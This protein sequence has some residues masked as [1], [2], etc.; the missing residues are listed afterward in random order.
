MSN[1][2]LTI[3]MITKEALRV[4]H[5]EATVLKKVRRDYDD[6]FGRSGAKIGDTL[7]IRRPARYTVTNG[8][9]LQVQDSVETF[10]S[11]P[12]TSQKGVHIAFS[13][14]EMALDIDDYSARY[15]RPA[16]SQLAAQ[17]ESDFIQFAKNQTF[18]TVGAHNANLSTLTTVLNARQRLNQQL[19]PQTP[20]SLV[21][22]PQAEATLVGG[23]SNLFNSQTQV[24]KQYESGS[25]GKAAGFDFYASA[26]MPVHTNGTAVVTG[27]TVN[28]ANQV[29]A[30]IS[31]SSMGANATIPAGTVLT[32]AGC[33]AVNPETKQNLGYLQ[34]FVVTA[35]TTATGAGAVAALPISPAIVTSGPFQNVSASPTASG[36][37]V[38]FGA[39]SGAYDVSLAMHED[40]F[41]FA[42]ADL[43]LPPNVEASRQEMGGLSLRALKVYDQIND[44]SVIRI[45]SLYGFCAL[46]PQLAVKIANSVTT[47]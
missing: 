39:A 34:Q 14:A 16:M 23:L 11:L 38:I 8:R 44:Q 9:T 45:D 27:G 36:A 18:Q 33:N 26:L 19:A 4:L 35:D 3:D 21:L 40:A 32:F 41:A 17:M 2:N 42:T 47:I 15:L 30:T 6:R 13:S 1:T 5:Q 37:V 43:D 29:G 12:V 7:R 10:A 25:M 22:N 20:R 28:G 24:A 46:Y 31:L